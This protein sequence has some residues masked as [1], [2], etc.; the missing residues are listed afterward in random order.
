MIDFAHLLT[1]FSCALLLIVGA[2]LKAAMLCSEIVQYPSESTLAQ[3]LFEKHGGGFEIYTWS[4][5]PHGS[6]LGTSSILAG[7]IMAALWKSSGKAFDISSLNHAV[8]I[9]VLGLL[10][11]FCTAHQRCYLCGTSHLTN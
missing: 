2:L 8:G 7:A 5:L 6:G 11:D 3:Q 9:Q 4:N 1:Y 10:N